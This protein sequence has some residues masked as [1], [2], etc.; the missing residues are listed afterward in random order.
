MVCV[1]GDNRLAGGI[2]PSDR[3]TPR[4]TAPAAGLAAGHDPHGFPSRW[5]AGLA[6]RE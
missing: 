2:N 1:F 5:R 6:G 4:E 3:R